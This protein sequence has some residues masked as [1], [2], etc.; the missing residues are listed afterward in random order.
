MD[1]AMTTAPPAG[2]RFMLSRRCKWVYLGHLTV[3]HGRGTVTSDTVV[4]HSIPKR[5]PERSPA[6][7]YA[8]GAAGISAPPVRAHV[9]QNVQVA[10]SSTALSTVVRLRMAP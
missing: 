8:R 5:A 1:V 6:A 2:V 7:L 9:S 3:L 10:T 4:L